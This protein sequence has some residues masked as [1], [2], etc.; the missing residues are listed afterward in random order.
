MF[1]NLSVGDPAPL[2]WRHNTG[3]V[4]NG[5]LVDLATNLWWDGAA[6]GASPVDVSA[7]E[8]GTTGLYKYT[9]PAGLSGHY[10]LYMD[11][12]GGDCCEHQIYLGKIAGTT[13]T[14]LCEVYGYVKDGSG[15]PISGAE[16][17]A[18]LIPLVVD[19]NTAYSTKIMVVRTNTDGY[20]SIKL[21]RDEN[22]VLDIPVSTYNKEV[23]VPDQASVELED[24]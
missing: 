2:I 24:L 9:L 15:E 8:I 5:R 3:A 6:W 1:V 18:R 23:T 14:D 16:V 12:A 13:D 4:V 22:Y 20:F 11:N 21:K 19:G 17:N 10:Y 7:P